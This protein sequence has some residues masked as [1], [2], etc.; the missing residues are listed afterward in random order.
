[1][2][3]I[4]DIKDDQTFQWTNHAKRKLF[5]YRLGPAKIKS[6]IRHPA[7]LEQ[8]I[9]Q[10]LTAAMRPGGSRKNPYEIWTMFE[11]IEIKNQK[12]KLGIK[13]LKNKAKKIKLKPQKKIKIISCWRYPGK[14]KPG[15]PVPIPEDVISELGIAS[16]KIAGFEE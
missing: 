16:E 12:L 4:K 1:M 7:R 10:G 5:Y 3:D 13:N 15:K 6:I 9:V 8:S 2:Q 11:I 14:T